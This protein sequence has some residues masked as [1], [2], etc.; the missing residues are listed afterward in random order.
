MFCWDAKQNSVT[1]TLWLN[2][3][4]INIRIVVAVCNKVARC[5]HS[6]LTGS[7]YSLQYARPRFTEHNGTNTHYSLSL[8]SVY[9]Y[10]VRAYIHKNLGVYLYLCCKQRTDNVRNNTIDNDVK[11]F[12]KKDCIVRGSTGGGEINLA[13]NPAGLLVCEFLLHYYI[14][15]GMCRPDSTAWLLVFILCVSTPSFILSYR[16]NLISVLLR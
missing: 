6:V 13:E 7:L 2:R 11:T 8:Y 5:S 9:V 14:S 15:T 1:K 4:Q 12:I 10:S 3:Q 16:F